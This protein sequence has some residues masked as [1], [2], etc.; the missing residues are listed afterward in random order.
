M[1]PLESNDEKR[2][3]CR[4]HNKPPYRAHYLVALCLL[5][6]LTTSLALWAVLHTWHLQLSPNLPHHQQHTHHQPPPTHSPRLTNCGST[7]TEARSRGCRFDILSFAWQT[8][9]CYDG[10]LMDAFMRHAAWQFYARPNRTDETV[11]L[12]IAL[13]GEQTLYV[14]WD[15]H[16][17]HCTY[18]WR[19][20]HRAYAVRGWV[21]AHLDSYTHTLHC[22]RVLLDRGVDGGVVNVVAA[23]K[24][25]ECRE[26]GGRGF[27]KA[28]DG[29]EVF[30]AKGGRL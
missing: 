30:G 12:A 4:D 6:L 10:E 11:S 15:Y 3:R 1:H 26:V 7:P 19:Q 9:E 20:L 24:Y 22:Q 16:V 5:P 27:R 18:M 14:D 21:D 2:C 28:G 29:V 23:L 13:Q 25:P 17:A 8:P